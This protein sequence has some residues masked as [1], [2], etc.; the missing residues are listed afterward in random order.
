MLQPQARAAR[1]L[2]PARP[3][4]ASF[5]AQ[6]VALDPRPIGMPQEVTYR[7]I[8]GSCHCGNIRFT[9]DWPRAA[10]TIPADAA[11]ASALIASSSPP[12]A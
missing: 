3:A 4:R 6:P 5:A 2:V 12:L 11:P 10:P 9:F 8:D 7:R 1:M